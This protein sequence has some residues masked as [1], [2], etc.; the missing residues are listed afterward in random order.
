[1]FVFGV[2]VVFI[3]VYFEEGL[4]FFYFGFDIIYN[5]F[6]FFFVLVCLDE[7]VGFYIFGIVVF[8]DSGVDKFIDGGDIGSRLFDEF[9]DS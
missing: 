4:W 8:G 3:G 6:D 5:F 1:M 2:V 9:W 7:F